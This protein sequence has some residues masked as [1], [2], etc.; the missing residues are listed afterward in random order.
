MTEGEEYKSL[1]P[2]SGQVKAKQFSFYIYRSIR[3][4]S[5]KQPAHPDSERN[6]RKQRKKSTRGFRGGC[7]ISSDAGI[8]CLAIDTIEPLVNG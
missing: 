2:H 7:G 8:E 4:G 3:G 1:Y 6:K 5:S